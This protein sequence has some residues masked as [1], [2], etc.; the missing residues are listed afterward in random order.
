MAHDLEG[1]LPI[2]LHK[3]NWLGE[4]GQGWWPRE[5]EGPRQEARLALFAERSDVGTQATEG[6]GTGGVAQG[7]GDL[8]LPLAQALV[9]RGLNIVEGPGPVLQAGAHGVRADP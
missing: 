3:R 4:G 5:R 6:V 1:D 8:L 7:A 2:M 9:A